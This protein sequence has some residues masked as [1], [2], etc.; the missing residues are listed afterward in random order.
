MKGWFKKEKSDNNFLI[1]NHKLQEKIKELEEELSKL[2]QENINLKNQLNK[3]E[4]QID[5]LNLCYSCLKNVESNLTIIAEDTH[6]NINYFAN[7]TKDN[8]QVKEE[9]V[10][11]RKVFEKFLKEIDALMKFSSIAIENIDNLNESVD[12]INSVINLIKDIA[13][14][15]NLLALNAAI[16]AA[17]AGEHGRGF[18]VVADEVRKLAERTQNATKEVEVTIN[19]LKQNSS[20]MTDEG[21]N[22]DNI[23]NEMQNFMNEFKEGFDNLSSLDDRLFSRFS[24]L[25]DALTAIEQKINN[26]LFKIK[27]YKEKIM[28]DGKYS[29]DIGA[30]S[31]D[32]WYEGVGKEA[33]SETNSYRDIKSTQSRFEN[34]LKDS[35][36][37]SMKDSLKS[38]KKAE[39]ETIQMYKDLDNMIKEK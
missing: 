13:D 6:N 4:L 14:Q 3:K 31:F 27:N 36:D 33:F 21:K 34:H 24:H 20:N 23:I 11:I 39:L 2:E 25:A 37:L 18:A 38:F 35:M 15:T 28:G 22:L 7:M 12:N 5:K 9:I 26:L 19:V 16:E 10:D 30:H 32:T 29:E 8:E 1:E 17:R